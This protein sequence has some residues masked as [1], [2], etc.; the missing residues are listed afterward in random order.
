MCCDQVSPLPY[1][2]SHRHPNATMSDHVMTS[3][4]FAMNCH[5]VCARSECGEVEKAF[6]II[7]VAV[8]FILPSDDMG[9]VGHT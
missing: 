9:V 4:P 7:H 5:D 2:N 8:D 1:S 6:K 3:K